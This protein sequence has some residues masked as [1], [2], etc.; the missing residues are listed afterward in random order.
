MQ[1]LREQFDS[2]QEQIQN[3]HEFKSIKKQAQQRRREWRLERQTLIN[4][5]FKMQ[6]ILRVIFCL[7]YKKSTKN[8]F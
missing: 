5:I 8:H 2:V 3:E 6:N 1:A 4:I 7:F